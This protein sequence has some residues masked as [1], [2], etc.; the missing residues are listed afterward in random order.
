VIKLIALGLGL[1]TA[2]MA[3]LLSPGPGE[4]ALCEADLVPRLQARLAQP[5]LD[6]ADLG[7][8]LQTLAGPGQPQRT[9]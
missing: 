8:V 9:L 1:V 7:M 4:A 2:G 6:R 5:P 3:A